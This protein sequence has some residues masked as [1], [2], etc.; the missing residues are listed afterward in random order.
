MDNNEV[1]KTQEVFVPEVAPKID[2]KLLVRLMVVVVGL[3]NAVAA[4]FGSAFSI[5][6]NAEHQQAWYEIFSAAWL[7]GSVIWAVWKNNDI[8]KKARIKAQVAKQVEVKK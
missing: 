1:Q 6:L 7:V 5:E 8:T 4:M 3:I 2:P